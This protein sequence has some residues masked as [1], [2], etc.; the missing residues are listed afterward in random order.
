[1]GPDCEI[2]ATISYILYMDEIM[3]YPRNERD[4]DSQ[5]H[6]TKIQSRDG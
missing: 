3:L 5:I 4:M 6:P 1:M 2:V